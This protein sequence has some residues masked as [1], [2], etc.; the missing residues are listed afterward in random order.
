MVFHLF[1]R[2]KSERI[3]F[4]LL[5]DHHFWSV[6]FMLQINKTSDTEFRLLAH[7]SYRHEYDLIYSTISNVISSVQT[8]QTNAYLFE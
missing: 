2:K 5:P 3:K 1:G 7:L 6:L 8:V 4:S